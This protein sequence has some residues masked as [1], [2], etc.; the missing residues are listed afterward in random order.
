[1]LFS[2]STFAFSVIYRILKNFYLVLVEV[3]PDELDNFEWNLYSVADTWCLERHSEIVPDVSTFNKEA[4]A[5]MR[6]RG[7]SIIV[8]PLGCKPLTQRF[9]EEATVDSIRHS[10]FDAV[11]WLVGYAQVKRVGE[12][13]H[14]GRYTGGRRF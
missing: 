6:F 12:V 2:L 4:V 1:M 11:L 10:V 8:I 13:A 5:A 9:I 3:E 7:N 14:C